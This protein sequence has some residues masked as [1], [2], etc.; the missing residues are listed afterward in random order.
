MQTTYN[1]SHA[2]GLEGA[3][4]DCTNRRVESKLTE[5]AVIAGRAVTF[6]TNADTQ[7]KLIGTGLAFAGVA[8]QHSGVL[9]DDST[10]LASY[11]DQDDMS[12]ITAGRVWVHVDNAVA[13]NAPAYALVAGEIG[14]FTDVVGTNIA[15]GGKFITS[16]ASAGLA[17][18]EL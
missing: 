1:E 8:L 12:I 9:L 3:S 11:A 18:L 17:I 16:T 7:R 10:G 5:G 4:V 6:G 14:R 2:K 13:V 15:T